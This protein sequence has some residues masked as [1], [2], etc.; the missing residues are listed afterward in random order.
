MTNELEIGKEERMKLKELLEIK[1]GATLLLLGEALDIVKVVK[2]RGATSSWIEFVALAETGR[3]IA[4]EVEDRKVRVWLETSELPLDAKTMAPVT[5]LDA[6]RIIY[7]VTPFELTEGP[8]RARAESI[9]K[10][11]VE[12][13][14]IMFAVFSPEEGDEDSDERVCLEE[15][16]GR[17]TAYHSVGFVPAKEIQAK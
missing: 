17:L 3:E 4:L 9:T 5:S 7:G 15:K 2:S 16:S 12:L 14:K 1:P 13:A 8:S 6:D 11:G 10:E